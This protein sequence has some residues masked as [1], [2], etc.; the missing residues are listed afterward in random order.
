[1]LSKPPGGLGEWVLT[2][3]SGDDS[4]SACIASETS[5]EQLIPE[6][7][8]ETAI[9]GWSNFHFCH[10]CRWCMALNELVMESG[11]CFPYTCLLTPR[12]LENGHRNS[13]AEELD[14]SM[15]FLPQGTCFYLSDLFQMHLI[16]E[17]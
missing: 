16:F 17:I 15:A 10:L 4:Q 1:M 5:T 9:Q 6:D 13:V 12:K 2:L 7:I 8:G 3:V 14:I 11:Y